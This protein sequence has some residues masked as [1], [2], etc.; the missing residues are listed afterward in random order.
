MNFQLTV[1]SCLSVMRYVVIDSISKGLINLYEQFIDKIIKF[2]FLPY[3]SKEIISFGLTILLMR[4]S[5]KN[6]II[7][8]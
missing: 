6:D 7:N 1:I 3:I 5:L 4:F 8:N 2:S